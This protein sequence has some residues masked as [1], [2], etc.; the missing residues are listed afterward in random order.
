MQTILSLLFVVISLAGI[1]DAG[2]ITYTEYLQPGKEVI[3]GPGF[4]CGAVLNSPYARI[5]SV[6]LAAIGLVFYLTVFILAILHFLEIDINKYFRLAADKLKLSK[7]NPLRFVTTIEVI[8]ALT[9][10]GALFS[11]YLVFIMGVVIQAWCQFCLISAMTSLSLFLITV[12]YTNYFQKHSPFAIKAVWFSV[13]HFLYTNVLKPILFL[14]DAEAVHN[15]FTSTGKALGSLPLAK[16]LTHAAFA[17]DHPAASKKI[18]GITFPN[19]VGLAAG[20]DYNGQLTQ[21]LPSVGFGWHT[22]GTVTYEPYEGNPKP[23]L[24][25]FKESKGLLVNKGLKGLGAKAIIRFLENKQ[26]TIPTGISIASTNKTFKSTKEQILDIIMS[27]QLF[28]DSRVK[29]SYYELNISCPNTFGGEPFT[30]PER[31]ELLLTAL[32]KIKVS[33]PVYVKMP[34]DQSEEETLDLLEVIV[35]HKLTGVIFGNLTKDRDN[36]A[37]SDNDRKIWKQ[38]KGNVSGRPTWEISNALIRLTKK[39]Y[40]KK[41]TII[42]TGG[43]FSAKDAEMKMKLGA[44]LVQIISGM[45]FEGPQVLGQITSQVSRNKLK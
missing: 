19:P 42:G 28:E 36:P 14:F 11:L 17:F 13:I 3:C 34:I 15:G 20:F 7:L 38:C 33:K 9:I 29:H 12:F 41:L 4:D 40:G 37:I 39:T 25:R 26:F 24:G 35:R 45:I 32:D 22:I 16:K 8:Q 6:P 23:R 18:E 2:Y 44:D 43:I 5:G 30:S 31:L 27:F 1:A 10:F 21:I